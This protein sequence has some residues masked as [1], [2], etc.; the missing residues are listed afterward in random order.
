MFCATIFFEGKQPKEKMKGG[1]PMSALQRGL[2]WGGLGFAII[3][4]GVVLAWLLWPKQPPEPQISVKYSPTREIT[5]DTTIDF[6]CLASLPGIPTQSARYQWDFGDGFSGSGKQATHQYE[7]E[8]TYD[9]TCTAELTDRSGRTYIATSTVTVIVELPQLPEITADF[10]YTPSQPSTKEPVLFDASASRPTTPVSPSIKLQ[11]EYIWDIAG[12]S[13][14]GQ[15]VEYQFRRPVKE[16]PVTLTVRAR[17][18]FGRATKIARIEKSITIKFPDDSVIPSAKP[19]GP[20]EE[21]KYVT[22]KPVEFEVAVAKEVDN[23]DLVFQWDFNNDGIIDVNGPIRTVPWKFIKEGAYTVIVKIP[24]L[25]LEK[26]LEVIVKELPPPPFGPFVASGGM[27]VIGELQLW[28]VAAGMNIPNTTFDILVGY[29]S[30]M[31]TATIDR[32]RDYSEVT[33][34]FPDEPKARVKT[35]IKSASIFSVSVWYQAYQDIL[36]GGGLGY[37]MLKGVHRSDYPRILVD[38]QWPEAPFNRDVIVLMFGVAYKV[39]F[40]LISLQVNYALR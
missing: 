36:V 13:L 27:G 39:G 9:V 23:K 22:G 17:D 34:A 2:L 18:Q 21:Y 15:Q 1:K 25:G 10:S 38:S 32:T 26:T 35:V 33:Q 40:A 30:N 8:G 20:N 24:E 14:K 6:T 16:L 5:I 37:L 4:V 19:N 31:N 11:W 3:I 12:T 29:G 28:N 7:E